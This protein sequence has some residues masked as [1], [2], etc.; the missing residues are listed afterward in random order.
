VLDQFVTSASPFRRNEVDVAQSTTVLGG[1][2]L[3]LKQHATLGETL[4]NETGMSAT[5][6][7]PGASRPIIRGLGGDR[8]RLLENSVGTVDASVTSPDHAVSIEPF[9]VERI[10]IVRGPASLLYGSTA[11]G[12]LVNVITRRIAT[13]LPEQRVRGGAELR[14]GTGAEEFAGGGVLD[15]NLS[16]APAQ[17]LM[18]HLDRFHRRAGDLRIPGFAESPRVRATEA[19]EAAAGGEA[20]ETPARGRLPNSALDTD[21]AA[22]GLSF[23][24]KTFHLGASY[25]KFDTLYGVPG[26]AH[27]VVA[28]PGH[29]PGVRI[30][31]SQRRTA[32]DSEWRRDSGLVS[33]LRL[34]V[35]HGDY[36]HRELEPDGSVG[37][38]F[39]NRG[40]DARLELLH[41]GARNLN[42]AVGVQA[43]R[44]RL[45]AIGEEAFLPPSLARS[46]ALFVFEEAVRGPMTWQFG[47][48]VDD[49]RIDADGADLREDQQLSGSIGVVWKRTEADAIAVTVAHT[50]RAPNT[51]E[52]FAHGPHAGTQAF[53]VGDPLLEAEKSLGLELSFRRRTGRVTGEVTLFTNRF[54]DY[55]FAQPTG[56]VA[57]ETGDGFDFVPADGG[58]EGLPVLNTVQRDAA[59]WGAE[60]ETTWHLHEAG[61]S[62]FDLKLAAD[63]TRARERGANLP[64]IPAARLMSGLEWTRGAWAAGIDWQF[65]FDQNR[66]AP[67]ETASDGY[68]LI[69]AQLTWTEVRGRVTHEFFLRGTNLANAEARPH[70]SFLKELAPLGGRAVTAGTR[71]AGG[72]S[73]PTAVVETG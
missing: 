38:L 9:L 60:L 1:Q 52:L 14:Y 23:V 56:L 54:D 73:T 12:G 2:A 18:L 43:T 30:D 44:N 3:L 37:T 35:G 58:T 42:G 64:R 34:K 29:A 48:R 53:E 13:E 32:F 16:S 33:G 47:A 31:L 22:A 66:V 6:F 49:T 27:D 70:P 50:G 46:T 10:E 71:A 36:E 24:R 7:G 17:A 21:G 19:L 40:F 72:G 55:I 65:V 51:Q 69:G 25:S 28:A 20:P 57:V 61:K 68:E 63:F 26:H 62:K 15:V 41:G 4:A 5:S 67:D 45:T 39:T 11:V 59:F 8:I